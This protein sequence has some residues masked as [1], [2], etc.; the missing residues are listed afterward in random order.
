LLFRLA[1]STYH[2][3][4]LANIHNQIALLYAAV[5]SKKPIVLKKFWL[6]NIV[7]FEYYHELVHFIQQILILSR[8]TIHSVVFGAIVRCWQL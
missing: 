2:I 7:A 8:Q 6:R 5:V 3:K 4:Q 1:F